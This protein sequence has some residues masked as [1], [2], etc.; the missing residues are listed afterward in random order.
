MWPHVASWGPHQD[1]APAVLSRSKEKAAQQQQ[2]PADLHVASVGASMIKYISLH[3]MMWAICLALYVV[4]LFLRAVVFP[5]PTNLAQQLFWD[6][7]TSL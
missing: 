1:F 7:D 6:P 4:R 5:T 2:L 3:R